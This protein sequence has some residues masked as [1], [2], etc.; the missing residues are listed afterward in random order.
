MR[1]MRLG[2]LAA[3]IVAVM[4][5]AT[6]MAQRLPAAAG[7]GARKARP[8]P[9]AAEPRKDGMKDAPAVLQAAGSSCQL[10]DAR[11]AGTM[12]ADKKTGSLGGKVYE[13]ACGEGSVGFVAVANVAGPPTLLSCVLSNYPADM[14]PPPNPCILPTNLDL[15]PTLIAFAKKAKVP[16]VPD[17]VRGIGQTKTNTLIEVSCPGGAGYIVTG[18]APLDVN[19]DATS[20]NCL[21]YDAVEGNGAEVQTRTTPAKRAWRRGPTTSPR[22]GQERLRREGP[23]LRGHLHRRHG[24]L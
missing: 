13:I 23:P 5:P 18:S 11:L 24:R 8:R 2:L 3:L 16:C 10:S 20:A 9:S 19:K 12:A 7:G 22:A 14:A 15:A 4:A 1:P 21:A 6:A 17:K